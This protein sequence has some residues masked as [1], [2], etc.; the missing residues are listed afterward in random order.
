MWRW[1]VVGD[2]IRRVYLSTM[3]G[4]PQVA[5]LTGP[6]GGP[7]DYMASGA[8]FLRIW[9]ELELA[10]AAL[11]PFGTV[12]TNPSSHAQF[13][14]EVGAREPEGELVWMLFRLGYSAPPPQAHRRP[15][16][17]MMVP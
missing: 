5:W 8:L 16:T 14:Q 6:F 3:R 17:E 10:G 13:V 12:I 2:V 4:V 1:P 9:L 11:H 7:L 15:L